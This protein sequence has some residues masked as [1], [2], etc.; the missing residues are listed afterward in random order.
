MSLPFLINDYIS[1]FPNLEEFRS[2]LYKKNILSKDYIEEGLMLIYHKYDQKN[3][4]DLE[5]ECRSIILDRTTKKI[6]SYSC[7]NPVLNVD[8]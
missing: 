3:N 1:K 6:L 5:M 8:A 2:E 7:E 4:S